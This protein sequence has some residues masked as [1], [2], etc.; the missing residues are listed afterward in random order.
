M[1]S[2]SKSV[3]GLLV[4]IAIDRGL[5]KSVDDPVFDYLPAYADLKTPE[6]S[7]IRISDLLTMTAGLKADEDVPYQHPV[8]SE[9]LVATAPDPYRFALG[10]ELTFKPGTHWVYDGGSTMILSKVL[11]QVSGKSL[12]GFAEESL[13]SP[14]GITTFEW[15]GLKKS[16]EPAA[17]GSLRLRPRDLAKIG[18]L[19]LDN[20]AWQGKQIV[21]ADWIKAATTARQDGWFPMRYGYHW[22]VGTEMGAKRT[23]VD[24]V[25]GIGIGGQRVF[26]LPKQDVVVVVTAGMYDEDRQMAIPFDITTQYVLPAMTP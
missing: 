12:T 7:A 16:G 8:N 3:V 5:I 1:R 17:Y 24:W 22:W 15:I 14:L 11:Q 10:R 9:R 21:S 23:K 25:G 13:F 18:Q 26:V 2:I 20:G 4:G 6:N 19:V